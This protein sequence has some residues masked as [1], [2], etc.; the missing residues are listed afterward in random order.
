[1]LVA[2]VTFTGS[3]SLLLVRAYL[4]LIR[5]VLQVER[6][7][8]KEQ[9]T[10][11]YVEK[12]NKSFRSLLYTLPTTTNAYSEKKRKLKKHLTNKKRSP[13]VA[14]CIIFSVVVASSLSMYC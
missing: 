1:M 11:C 12:E 10:V 5:S 7:G 4:S 6:E 14:N 2:R 13:I 3:R 8:G 9:A